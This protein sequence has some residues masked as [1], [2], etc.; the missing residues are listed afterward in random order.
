MILDE[1]CKLTRRR[2]LTTIYMKM[3]LCPGDFAA[4]LVRALL[5]SLRLTTIV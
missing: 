4:R 5:C 3:T 1:G 2:C